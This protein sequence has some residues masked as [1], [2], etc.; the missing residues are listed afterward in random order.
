MLPM[1]SALRFANAIGAILM[2][3]PRHRR[4]NTAIHRQNDDS[5]CICPGM[6]QQKTEESGAIE[7]DLDVLITNFDKIRARELRK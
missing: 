7:I 3:P 2:F 4:V 6:A 1:A 5:W